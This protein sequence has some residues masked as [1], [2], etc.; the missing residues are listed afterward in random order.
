MALEEFCPP[1]LTVSLSNSIVV[2]HILNYRQRLPHEPTKIGTK[3][4][5][6]REYAN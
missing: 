3:V 1:L 2:K 4:L 6:G 5:L